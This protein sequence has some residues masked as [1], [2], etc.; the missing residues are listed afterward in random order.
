M[1]S[2]IESLKSEGRKIKSD[3]DQGKS[4]LGQFLMILVFAYVM[5]VVLPMMFTLAKADQ[6]LTFQPKID[7]SSHWV[8]PIQKTGAG[9]ELNAVVARFSQKCIPGIMKIGY[10]WESTWR[11]AREICETLSGQ[12]DHETVGTWSDTIKGDSGCSTGLGQWNSCPASKRKAA[13]GLEAQMDQLIDEM[14]HKIAFHPLDTAICLHNSP[15]GRCA[16]DH[17][18]NGKFVLGYVSKVKLSAKLFN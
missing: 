15:A 16:V 18:K 11:R 17:W 10:G 2:P 1:K 9:P 12:I 8:I 5:S 13:K 4:A 7:F 3:W 6:E 14:G